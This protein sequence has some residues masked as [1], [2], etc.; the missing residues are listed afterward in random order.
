MLPAYEGRAVMQGHLM[1]QDGS[2]HRVGDSWTEIECFRCGVCCV[3]YRPKVTPG[4][5][6]RIARK[7]GIS[8]DEFFSTYTR[9][10]PTKDRYILQTSADTCPFLGWD[11]Y[12]VKATCTIHSVRPKA[13]RNWVASLSRPEC[14]EG[15]AKMKAGG[16]LLLPGDVY[17]SSKQIKRLSSVARDNGGM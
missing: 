6:K 17:Q 5:M 4:E 12:G 14:Q 8:P 16:A 7:L 1:M 11:E 10:V 13:C 9:I 15:L 2:E 3:R